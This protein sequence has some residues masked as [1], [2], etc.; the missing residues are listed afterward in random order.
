VAADAQWPAPGDSLRALVLPKER[1]ERLRY[2]WWSTL[3]LVADGKEYRPQINFWRRGKVL[4][5]LRGKEWR[6]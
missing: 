4:R 2:P 5:F 6:I 1:V 3:A